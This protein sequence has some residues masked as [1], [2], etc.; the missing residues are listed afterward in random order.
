MVKV[1]QGLLVELQVSRSKEEAALAEMVKQREDELEK[2]HQFRQMELEKRHHLRKMEKQMQKQKEL[3]KNARRSLQFGSNRGKQH[4]Q[5]VRQRDKDAR[6]DF[7]PGIMRG[8]SPHGS[9]L[10][11]RRPTPSASSLQ[12]SSRCALPCPRAQKSESHA[13]SAQAPGLP[14]N[15][16]DWY[17]EPEH[18]PL[19][20]HTPICAKLGVSAGGGDGGGGGG[21][22]RTVE[23]LRGRLLAERVASKA[24]KEEADQL[25]KRLDELEKKLAD[26]VKVRNKAERRLR[27]A[28]KKLESLKILDVELSDGS[29]GSLSSNGRSGHQAPEVEVEV[30]VEAEE[31]NSSGSLTTD[32]SVPSAPSGDADADADADRDIVRES[33]EGSCT[34]VNSSSQDGSWCSVVSEQSWPGSCMDLAG[35]TTN[36]SSEESGGDH[37]SER[38][39]LDASSGCGSAKSEEAFYESDN[40]LALVLVDPQLV[41]AAAADDDGP[42]TQDNETQAGEARAR[43]HEEERQEEEEANKL[44]IVL[45]DT[46][47]QPVAAAAQTGPPKPHGDVESVLLALRRVK[48]QLRYTIE[49][50][51]QLVVAHQE[52][53][54]H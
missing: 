33:S 25:A 27:T 1:F 20:Y 2:W 11:Q 50:R 15:A 18:H 3:E 26:E 46:Q 19:P 21:G 42:R 54:D 44:A 4:R 30:E 29:I 5:L 49:R 48:E 7:C 13:R 23:C 41:A 17:P 9:R 28:I 37:D 35:N 36:C 10:E 16:A 34:Q 38:Q 43:S 8:A 52:L 22:M 51:S 40:R 32:G 12:F 39:H 14:P 53:Y 45:F 6:R 24:A 31:R 47:P